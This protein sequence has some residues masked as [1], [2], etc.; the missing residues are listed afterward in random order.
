MTK[1]NNS[2]Y[3]TKEEEVYHKI[4]QRRR[5]ILVHSY[6]YYELDDSLVGDSKWSKWARELVD[7]QKSYP[8]ISKE[9]P[10][11]EDF[12]DFDASTGFDF[13]YDEKTKKR[14]EMLLSI[15]GE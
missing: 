3:P 7:L 9:V 15:R 1:Q 5:Q 13:K 6:I 11:Y 14:A 10:Y 12:K 2:L 4:L 8:D